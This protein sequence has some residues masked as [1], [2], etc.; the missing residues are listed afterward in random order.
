[1]FCWICASE[2]EAFGV[3][4]IPPRTGRCPVCGAKPRYRALAWFLD[5]VARPRLDAGSQVLEV[6]PSRLSTTRLVRRETFGGGR[7]IAIDTRRLPHHGTLPAP[8]RFVQMDVTDLRFPD[9]HFDLILCNNILPYVRDDAAALRELRR[10]LKV[11]GVAMVNTHTHA[12]ATRTA[13]QLRAAYPDLG[14]DYFAENGDQ[15]AYGE[16]FPERVRAAGLTLRV[17]TLFADRDP[18]FVARNGLKARTEIMLAAR[19]PAGWAR[20]APGAR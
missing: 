18:G 20:F 13:S 10:C 4:G 7:Y 15:W 16:D 2:V 17:E 9:E 12:G 11:D 3:Y 1:M 8:H 19:A 5:E 6:G 14:D